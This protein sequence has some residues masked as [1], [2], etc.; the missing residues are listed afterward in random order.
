MNGRQV[1]QMDCKTFR[2]GG[3]VSR[4]GGN[5]VLPCLPR[6]FSQLPALFKA[7]RPASPILLRPSRAPG[8]VF[9][10]RRSL[11]T[12]IGTEVNFTLGRNLQVPDP[13]DGAAASSLG[14]RAALPHLKVD[15]RQASEPP[16][17]SPSCSV[18]GS[19]PAWK[20]PGS[21]RA[22]SASPAAP[23]VLL[24]PQ[25]GGRLRGGTEE[26]VQRAPAS[27][28]CPRPSP[29]HPLCSAIPVT[30]GRGSS[31]AEAWGLLPG[32]LWGRES[33]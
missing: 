24:R 6:L 2:N 12:A 14:P 31:T 28:H 33:P 7:T 5:R 29:P 13:W 27:Q 19:P 10:G 15:P 4:A 1:P 23:P 11:F 26:W 25:E 9:G 22:G 30:Q 21:W 20:Q 3:T 8:W 18:L 16:P 32:L 17:P